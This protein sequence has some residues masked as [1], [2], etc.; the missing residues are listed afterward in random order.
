[1][2]RILAC[3]LDCVLVATLR[4]CRFFSLSSKYGVD[5][6]FPIRSLPWLRWWGVRD[7]FYA[8]SLLGDVLGG[9]HYSLSWIAVLAFFG[10]LGRVRFSAR[11]CLFFVSFFVSYVLVGCSLSLSLWRGL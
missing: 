3:L 11:V 7:A 4:C 10:A 9:A 8:D 5:R 1:M 6:L 2:S